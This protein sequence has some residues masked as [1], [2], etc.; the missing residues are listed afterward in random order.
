[1]II[2]AAKGARH[3]RCS[4][5]VWRSTKREKTE[6]DIN[7]LGE[8][9]TLC[10]RRAFTALTLSRFIAQLLPRKCTKLELWCDTKL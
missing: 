7:L 4:R 9:S 2:R 6:I 1:M 3:V 10:H 8:A 5:M